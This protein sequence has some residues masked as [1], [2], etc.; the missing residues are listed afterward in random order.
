M[1]SANGMSRAGEHDAMPES[2]NMHLSHVSYLSLRVHLKIRSHKL[3]T[4]LGAEVREPET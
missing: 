3:M 4:C 2:K 1:V